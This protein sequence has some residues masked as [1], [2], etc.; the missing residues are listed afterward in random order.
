MSADTVIVCRF[1]FRELRSGQ[2]SDVYHPS[3]ENSDALLMKKAFVSSISASLQVSD[4]I[5]KPLAIIPGILSLLFNTS[6]KKLTMLVS[7][8]RFY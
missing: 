4:S 2:I 5:W 6:L 3:D 1:L 8:S 7:A